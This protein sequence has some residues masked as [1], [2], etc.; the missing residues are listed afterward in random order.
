MLYFIQNKIKTNLKKPYTKKIFSIYWIPKIKKTNNIQFSGEV[1][2]T[3]H[4]L[5]IAGGTVKWYNFYGNQFRKYFENCKYIGLTEQFHFGNF[6]HILVHLQN[7]L[8]LRFL[9]ATSTK[10]PSTGTGAMHHGTDIT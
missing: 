5:Y 8:F 3:R 10:C 7:N 4:P 2:V 9:I 1:W 6:S